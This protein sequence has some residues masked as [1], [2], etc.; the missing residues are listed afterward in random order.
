MN[1]SSGSDSL[2]IIVKLE[3][4]PS[5]LISENKMSKVIIKHKMQLLFCNAL[6]E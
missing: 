3:V 2:E 4:L 6:I 1:I 5:L